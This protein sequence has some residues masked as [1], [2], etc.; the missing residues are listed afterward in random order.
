MYVKNKYFYF[1]VPFG[2]RGAFLVPLIKE[3]KNENF[4]KS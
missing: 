2:R 3:Y 4:R 1:V